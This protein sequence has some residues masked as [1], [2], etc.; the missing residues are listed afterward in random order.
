MK[1]RLGSTSYNGERLA[2]DEFGFVIGPLSQNPTSEIREMVFPCRGGR[3]DHCIIRIRKGVPE[4]TTFG[5]DGNMAEPTITPSIGCDHR[6]GWHGHITKG[7][8]TP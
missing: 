2:A 6:C 8:V 1:L 3:F 4:G 5:W 7:D